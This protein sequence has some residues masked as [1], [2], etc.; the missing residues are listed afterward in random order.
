MKDMT[1]LRLG[2]P[3]C[4]N[5]EEEKKVTIS[6]GGEGSPLVPYFNPNLPGPQITWKWTMHTDKLTTKCHLCAYLQA[7][8]LNVQDLGLATHDIEGSQR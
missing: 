7:R 5:T 1:N 3:R 2:K 8:W 6:P 4:E